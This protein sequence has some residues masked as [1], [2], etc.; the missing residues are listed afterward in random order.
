M[1]FALKYMYMAHTGFAIAGTVVLLLGISLII[2]A[3]VMRYKKRKAEPGNES[4][5]LRRRGRLSLIIASFLIIPAAICF[6]KASK[7]FDIANAV[8]KGYEIYIDGTKAEGF[9]ASIFPGIRSYE[10]QEGGKTVRII[11]EEAH[12]DINKKDDITD[13]FDISDIDLLR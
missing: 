13:Y 7:G 1:G 9:D 8:H 2:A 3:I 11:T 10:I 4:D 6:N 5:K 12:E